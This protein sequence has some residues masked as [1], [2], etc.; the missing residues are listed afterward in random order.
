MGKTQQQQTGDIARKQQN[1][2]PKSININ[3]LIGYK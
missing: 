2:Q 3:K 1:D